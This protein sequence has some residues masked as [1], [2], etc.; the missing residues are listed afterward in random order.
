[1]TPGILEPPGAS[2][3]WFHNYFLRCLEARHEFTRCL[4]IIVW[5]S[6]P[7]AGLR[8]A[9]PRESLDRCW[10]TD[11]PAWDEQQQ[12]TKEFVGQLDDPRRDPD[13]TMGNV[14]TAHQLQKL[15]QPACQTLDHYRK[16]VDHF[17]APKFGRVVGN[18]LDSKHALAFGVHPQGQPPKVNF[19][20]RQIVLRSLDHAFK[21]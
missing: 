15:F 17:P 8:A 4:A 2:K 12:L 1:M 6:S 10:P 20:N 18:R 14:N 3:K 21:P 19:E 5:F 9:L 13:H 16:L 7:K 11:I